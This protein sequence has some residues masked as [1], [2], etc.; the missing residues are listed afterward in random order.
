M[1]M[2]NRSLFVGALL[3][4]FYAATAWAQPGGGATPAP[5]QPG[6]SFKP[7]P[8]PPKPGEILSEFLQG[9]LKL[10]PEQKKQLD[11]LQ[12]DVEAN[13]SKLL[14][15]EQKKSLDEMKQGKG[16]FGFGPGGFGPPGFGP[17]G[18]PG[19][20]PP[21]GT[22]GGPPP[23]MGFGPPFFG[24]GSGTA[25]VQKKIGAT[26][27]EWKVISPKLQKVNTARR[28]LNGDNA[29]VP[30]LPSGIVGQA[31][32][33][34]KTVLDDPKH[35]KADVDEKIAG[36]RKARE[37]ARANLEEAQR[38]LMRMLTPDQQLIMISLGH[39]D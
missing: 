9:Q 22:P 32:A 24:P 39:L 28:A 27:E 6:G 31:Q 7:F 18:K 10:T 12:K 29:A 34:L 1:F 20:T 38:D 26:D 4:L 14:T 36:I 11:Q 17:G 25:N 37:Q 2:H 13:L 30:G 33:E 23:K 5:V 16:A 21:G 15:A 8:A 35:S 19:E 3:C